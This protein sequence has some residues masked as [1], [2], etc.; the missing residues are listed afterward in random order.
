MGLNLEARRKGRKVP[1]HQH[2]LDAAKA[3]AASATEF[4]NASRRPAGPAEWRQKGHNDFV[5]DVDRGAEERV[6][7]ILTDLVPDSTVMG[8]ELSPDAHSTGITWIV[9][10]LDGTTNYLHGYPWYAVSIAA[11]CDG[12]PIAAVVS[13][14]PRQETFTA[15]RGQGAW[16]G[17]ERLTVSP[18]DQPDASLI[19]TGFPFKKPELMTEYTDQFNT[20]M[21][22]TSGIR[23]AG[24]AALDLVDVAVGRFEGFWELDL[25]PWDIAA[26]VLLVREAGGVVTDKDASADVI[27]HGSVVAGNPSIHEWLIRTLQI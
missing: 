4:I 21:H 22:A 18:I 2:L 23:R 26:G 3:A 1:D 6:G 12:D 19:G 24:S 17:E 5:T 16:R 7:N 13:N 27:K 25:A 8:E 9:D 11:V 14:V 20:I 15:T 10:P